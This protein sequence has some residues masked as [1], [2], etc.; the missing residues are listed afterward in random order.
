[1]TSGRPRRLQ[2]RVCPHRA[3]RYISGK[4]WI[5]CHH[6]RIDCPTPDGASCSGVFFWRHYMPRSAPKPCTAPGCGALV[7]D[8]SGR[9]PKH[10]RTA[11]GKQ[12]T[13]TKRVTGRKLQQLREE[14][15]RR[16]PLC[17]ECERRGLVALAT[18]RDHI[19]PLAEG[20]ADIEDNVQGLCEPCHEEKSLQ[21][22]LRGQRRYRT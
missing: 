15:F 16:S 17:A 22:R 7:H 9:C 5:S 14:L 10:P 1:M 4:L 6:P 20:G 18:Q 2:K 12:P 19:K 11:W 13:A 8:G 21:E 3:F